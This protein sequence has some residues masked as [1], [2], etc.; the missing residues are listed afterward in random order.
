MAIS[1]EA[2]LAVD[3]GTGFRRPLSVDDFKVAATGAATQA[4]Q[5]GI[6]AAVSAQTAVVESL[7]TELAQKLEPGQ[8]VEISNDS[9]NPIPVSGTIALDSTALT[10]LQNVKVDVDQIN[11]N[12]DGVESLLAEIYARQ[13]DGSQVVTGPLTDAQLRAAAVPVSGTF[14]QATQPVSGPLTDTQL[15]ASA[16][17]VTVSNPFGGHVTVDNFPATQ[18][19]SGPLTDA[20]LRASAVPV[21]GTVTTSNPFG[22]DVT[23]RAARLLGHVTVDNASLAVTQ[24]GA[25]W[26]VTSD[27]ELPTAAALTDTDANPSA[28]YVGAAMMQW[29]GS[30]WRRVRSL[31]SIGDGGDGATH[32]AT[33]GFVYNGATWDRV[34]GA[35][36]GNPR[37]ATGL[38]QAALM[39]HYSAATFNPIKVAN[40]IGDASDGANA[41]SG[42]NWVFNGTTWDRLRDA[43]STNFTTG[44]G[45]LAVSPTIF[46][47]TNYSRQFAASGVGGDAH[48]GARLQSGTSWLYNGSTWDR[49]RSASA[50]GAGA[51]TTGVQ[52]TVPS[53][54]TGST[55]APQYAASWLGDANT[56][57]NAPGV[58]GFVFNG[59]T[60]DR[61]RGGAVQGTNMGVTGFLG[62]NLI[63]AHGSSAAYPIETA[64]GASVQDASNGRGALAVGPQLY[65]GT[66]L[67]WDRARSV[68]DDGQPQRGI[69]AVAP[70][71]G[72]RIST[73]V[74]VAVTSTGSQA[75]TPASMTGIVVGSV[76]TIDATGTKE[77]V[78]V[79]AITATTFTANFT[80]THLAN[81]TVTGYALDVTRDAV[82]ATNAND[83]KGVQATLPMIYTGS[84]YQ[85]MRSA[86][87]NGDATAGNQLPTAGSYVYNGTT[88]DRMRGYVSAG[89][90]GPGSLAVVPY[91]EWASGD[92]R[93]L[94]AAGSQG[95]A[96]A[97]D[98]AIP[99]ASWVYNGTNYNRQREATVGFAAVTTTGVPV[100]ALALSDGTNLRNIW[101]ASAQTDATSAINALAA[102]GMVYNGTTWDRLASK[103]QTG[104]TFT[105]TGALSVMP[106]LHDS[107]GNYRNWG[108][109]GFNGDGVNGANAG[110]VHPILFNGTNFDRLRTATAGTGTS[111][112]GVLGA[113]I[114]A[115][116]TASST[117]VR[118]VNATSDS[119]GSTNVLSVSNRLWNGSSLDRE[120]AN[121]EGTLLASA[122]R[123]STTVSSN[124]TN[125]NARGAIIYVNVTNASGTGGLTFF[126]YAVDP[127][128]GASRVIAQQTTAKTANGCYTMEY[129][130]GASSG[131]LFDSTTQGVLPRT[132]YV[133]ITHGDASSYTYSVG[134]SLIL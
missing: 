91:L 122:A 56:L 97:A 2:D 41:L 67:G 94:K 13:A 60:F 51:G 46:D 35:I 121:T 22:G 110:G 106:A 125:Y 23:D 66:S 115:W 54:Y 111:G 58:A 28:P 53:L 104:A 112:T 105:P 93:V 129:Y 30:A 15:R 36:D 73:T 39:A 127:V 128:S 63:G 113:A 132:W 107:S 31:S 5:A 101:T 17:P 4:T 119:Q 108:T 48:G 78:S 77:T 1:I 126:I 12:T 18:P 90:T 29:T 37:S 95:D 7:L 82:S 109:A 14:W 32:L 42:F 134:Y 68:T 33:G 50:S 117:Y 79:T 81:F 120:R 52:A 19:V 8:T 70:V 88:W 69:A 72:S 102:G 99:V 16:V 100:T 131:G 43:N 57:A 92:L 44:T 34:R 133:Q 96:W 116:D 11:V 87:G 55:Y 89:L 85:A 49:A 123:T 26:S 74:A 45:L 25:P 3:D 103:G 27:T 24:S 59:T 76:L 47:G 61:L 118:A 6:L 98:K 114:L 9:G 86:S 62:V 38:P 84:T 40:Q 83:G 10:A 65:N 20:Q 130:P 71:V 80:A 64:G 21:S 124:Q 75:V